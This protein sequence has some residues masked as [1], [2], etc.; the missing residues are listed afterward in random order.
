MS[1]TTG[2][3]ILVGAGP[4]DP[5]LITVRGSRAIEAADVIVYDHL[6]NPALLDLAAHAERI[7]VGKR[8]GRHTMPQSEINDLLAERAAAGLAVVRLKGGDPYVFGRGAEEAEFLAARGIP[9]EIVPGIPAAVGAAAYAGVPLT[10]R[11]YASSVA[12][13]TGHED[14][15]KAD[16]SVDWPHLARGVGTVVVYM[17]V[18]NLPQIAAKLIEHGR[19]PETPVAIV[20][21]ATTPA[22]RTVRGTLA[23]IGERAQAEN[24]RPPAIVIIGGVNRLGPALGWFEG[25]PLFGRTVVVTRARAQASELAGRLRSLGADALEMPAIKLLPP[26]SWDDVDRAV[27]TLA[28]TDWIVF[29]SSNGV[30]FFMQRL[31]DLGGDARRLA[32]ARI[33]AIGPGTARALGAHGLRADV[34]PETYV[35]EALAEAMLA[36]GDLRGKK[37]LLARSNIARDVLPTVLSDAGADVEDLVAYQTV[38]DEIDAARIAALAEQGRLDA[39]TFTSSSTVEFFIRGVGPEFMKERAERI[40]AV[41]IGPITSAALRAHGIEPAAEASEHTI[42]GLVEAL[43]QLLGATQ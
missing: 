34:Q 12:F 42:S 13:V 5:E 9:F 24:V 39:I 8:A 28:D 41:S 36:A 43:R 4:G 38:P 1:E 33:A 7:C 37:A 20:E 16:S 11:R 17:G 27:E 10:D 31:A 6:A 25:R 30:D 19:P 40:A 29:T 14:P 18:R 21:R 35:A 32:G 26:E 2:N 22:Q 15:N 3:V 23:H